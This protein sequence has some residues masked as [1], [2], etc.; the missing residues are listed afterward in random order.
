MAASFNVSAEFSP[1]TRRVPVRVAGSA[2]GSL[3]CLVVHRAVACAEAAEHL[4]RTAVERHP[5]QTG[6]ERDRQSFG[7][8]DTTKVLD[9]A[10]A[11]APESMK[12]CQMQWDAAPCAERRLVLLTDRLITGQMA[13]S[14]GRGVCSSRRGAVLSQSPGS[15]HLEAARRASIAFSDT[16]KRACLKEAAPR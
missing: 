6:D 3:P 15:V 14:T 7:F 13:V 1:S 8:Q 4:S 16:T 12:A 11:A 5:C 10:A 9:S 2:S